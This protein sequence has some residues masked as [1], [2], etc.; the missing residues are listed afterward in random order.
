MDRS[1]TPRALPTGSKNSSRNNNPC[2]DDDIELYVSAGRATTTIAWKS[3][4]H[5][6]LVYGNKQA[7]PLAVTV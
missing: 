6:G 1:G 4:V 7:S 5:F 3:S 2:V